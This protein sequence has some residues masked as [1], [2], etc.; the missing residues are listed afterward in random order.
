MNKFK[1]KSHKLQFAADREMG[2]K[3]VNANNLNKLWLP[4]IAL[5]NV[6]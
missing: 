4:T 1:K 6:M 5:A 2:F 3:K